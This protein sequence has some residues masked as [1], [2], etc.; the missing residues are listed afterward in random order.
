MD[1]SN[2]FVTTANL[3]DAGPDKLVGTTLAGRYL[4]ES[5][6]GQGGV[7]AVYLARDYKLHDKRV[8]VK[9]LLD[10]SLKDPLVQIK[11]QQEKE[12]LARLD[13]P[14][15]VV[16]TDSGEMPDGQPYLVMQYVE[17]MSLREAIKA[18][19]EGMEVQHAA[20]VIKQMGAALSA[21]HEKR[22]YHRD[23]KPENIM[24][25]RLVRGGEQVKILDFGVAKVKDSLVAPSLITGGATL[26][27]VLYM[28]P[29]QLQGLK[30]DSA[31]D[32]YSFGVIAYEM[33]TG[34]RPFNPETIGHLVEMHR[35]GVR[36]RPTDLRPRLSGDAERAILKALAFESQARYQNAGD[37]GDDLSRAL[38]GEAETIRRD[39]KDRVPIPPTE[40][41]SDSHPA[42]RPTSQPHADTLVTPFEPAS[43]KSF[44]QSVVPLEPETRK[45][46]WPVVV[47]LIGLAAILAL[48]SFLI[49]FKRQA[50]FGSRANPNSANPS[51]QRSLAYSL[52]VQKMRDGKS[53]KEPFESSGQEIFENGYK[54]RLN[55]RSPQAGYLYVFN[56]GAPE[57]DKTDFTI[58]YPTPVTNKGS[59]K[60][61]ANQAMQTNWNTFAGQTGT[62]KFWII[63][64]AS[65]VSELESAK[66]A[67]FKD[68]EGALSDPALVST[69]KDFLNK[70]A[71]PKPETTK[72]TSK[73]QTD[74]RG[75][76]DMLVKLVELE[77][78]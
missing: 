26:G 32:V 49:I 21:V 15:I 62:E 34:R 55:V 69:V 30:V 7:G 38:A 74:V 35:H 56:E 2:D 46:R 66:D 43:V 63:W 60:L 28:S 5:K 57:K 6:L 19:P 67:A 52:T 29:E 71:E 68:P 31:S 39:R 76:G 61:D 4:I 24:L 73:Q 50:L 72:N 40:V 78:R 58:I 59:A 77:H 1:N 9:V 75:N 27:T 14:G 51:A 45:R 47:G 37:F 33:L 17:G 53:Y 12:A 18:E 70:H 36:A 48:G 16:I 23:L 10:K 22:I 42:G 64:S 20:E 3:N 65:S 11:F 44:G 13:H 8:V 54:F 41:S 25:Q